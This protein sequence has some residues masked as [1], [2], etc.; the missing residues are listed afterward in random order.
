MKTLFSLAALL[1]LTLMSA[2]AQTSR[3]R[4]VHASSDAPAVDILVDGNVAFQGLRFRDY[5]NYTPVPSGMRMISINV[6]GTSTTALRLP[7][8]LADGVDYTFYAFGKL[9]NSTLTVIGTGD[10]LEAP[11]AN[12]TK[13]RVVHGA[14]TAPTVDIFVTAAFAALPSAPLLTG[15]PFTVA[16]HYL[17]VPAGDYQARVTPTGTRTVAIDSRRLRLTG[18]TIRTIVAV[19]GTDGTSFD[20]IVLNDLN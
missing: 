4:V 12:S 10:D 13:V 15:V 8:T 7:F 16:S 1:G 19:D 20:L 5:T 17:T 2:S 6:A 3:V 9:A 11:A 14:S 18:G